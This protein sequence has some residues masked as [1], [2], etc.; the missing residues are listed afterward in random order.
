MWDVKLV[1]EAWRQPYRSFFHGKVEISFVM[2]GRD[3]FWHG[4]VERTFW[5][6]KVEIPFG[7]ERSIA[8]FDM[9]RSIA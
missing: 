4:K 3:L 5:H 7:M 8:L 6:R 1:R 9:E 2:E